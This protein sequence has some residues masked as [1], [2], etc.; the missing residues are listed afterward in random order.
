M[1][2]IPS[3][4][5]TVSEFIEYKLSE[6]ETE[7]FYTTCLA[8]GLQIMMRSGTLTTADYL[9]EIHPILRT[10]RNASTNLDLLERRQSSIQQDLLDDVQDRRDR[11]IG[12][13]DVSAEQSYM[14]HNLLC[15]IKAA[16]Y[17]RKISFNRRI[18]KKRVMERYLTPAEWHR[19][20]SGPCYELSG[21]YHIYGGYPVPERRK[22]SH[23]V[24]K[25]LH[26]A[27]L[28]HLFG[29]GEDV[30]QDPGNGKVLSRQFMETLEPD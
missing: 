12:P 6:F 28:S 19:M 24:P 3:S 16:R 7:K 23:I 30:A 9:G 21:L 18:F 15:V 25:F 14:S 4:S 17:Y 27:E 1:T 22:I 5:S 2:A 29:V 26:K 13:V 20:G 8:Q 10:Y 11:L